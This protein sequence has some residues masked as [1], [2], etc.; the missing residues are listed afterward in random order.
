MNFF[1]KKI[2]SSVSNATYQALEIRC[3]NKS[4]EKPFNTRLNNHKKDIKGSNTMQIF[5]LHNHISN[6][7][8]QYMKIKQP[9]NKETN[10]SATFTERNSSLLKQISKYSALPTLLYLVSRRREVETPMLLQVQ[11]GMLLCLKN[12]C[13]LEL[14][15]RII[16]HQLSGSIYLILHHMFF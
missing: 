12:I 7:D 8:G 4:S 11:W 1:F 5:H 2:K 9:R 15:L 13:Y 10:L 3:N 6:K 14:K 16:M